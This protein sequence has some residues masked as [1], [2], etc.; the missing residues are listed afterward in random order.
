MAISRFFNQCNISSQEL[1]A[2][3]SDEH[4]DE[5]EA[6]VVASFHNQGMHRKSQGKSEVAPC[7]E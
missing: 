5:A 2:A 6:E 7:D 3:A 1:P 4:D